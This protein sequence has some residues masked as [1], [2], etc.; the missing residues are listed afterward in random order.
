MIYY[1]SKEGKTLEEIGSKSLF[2]FLE[3]FDI[4]QKV[5]ITNNKDVVYEGMI[6]DL[7]LKTMNMAYVK[8]NSVYLKDDI[9]VFL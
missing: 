9:I 8:D 3:Y 6:S 4:K 1:K 7:N 2:D 5:R